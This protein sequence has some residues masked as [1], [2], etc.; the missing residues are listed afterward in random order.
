M[1]KIPVTILTGFLGAGKTTVLNYILQN[2]PNIRFAII[3]N[4]IG[5][6][7][8]DKKLLKAENSAGVY[9]LTNGCICCTVGNDFEETL[10]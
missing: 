8:I 4:E 10:V 7:N 9:E 5:Q 3:E 2:E 6:I 1:H